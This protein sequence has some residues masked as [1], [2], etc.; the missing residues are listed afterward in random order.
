[1]L[2]KSHPVKSGAQF[3]RL[4][5]EGAGPLPALPSYYGRAGLNQHKA[6]AGRVPL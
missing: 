1:M 6:A 5:Q 4:P 3:R 2:V